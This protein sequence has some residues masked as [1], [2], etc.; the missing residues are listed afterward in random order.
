[1]INEVAAKRL[2]GA[3]LRPEK[4]LEILQ[5]IHDAHPDVGE[6]HMTL[7]YQEIRDEQIPGEV[8]PYIV[9]GLRGAVTHKEEEGV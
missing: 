3:K 2:L 1:M 5:S 4:L 7:D 9:L 6:A 8:I